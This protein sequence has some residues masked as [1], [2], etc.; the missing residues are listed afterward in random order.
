[1]KPVYITT[2]WDDGNASDMRVADLLLRY[3]LCGTFYVP[4]HFYKGVI[5]PSRYVDLGSNI[6]LGA[7]TIN[8]VTLT[9]VTDEQAQTEITDSK[10]WIEDHTG[11]DCVMFCP[12]NGKYSPAT[13]AP[14]MREA[15]F[16]ACRTVEGW[17]LDEPRQH[18]PLLNLPTSVQ[19]YPTTLSS[20]V[21]NLLKRRSWDGFK[22]YINHGIGHDWVTSLQRVARQ[23][24][25]HGGVIHLWGH[26]WEIDETHQWQ[27][28]ESA[29]RFLKQLCDST[30]AMAMTNGQ[31]AQAFV[32][33][34]ATPSS[35]AATSRVPHTAAKKHRIPKREW[36]TS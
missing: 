14:M 36:Q 18:G 8:H 32:P 1:M 28:L 29:C 15:N 3:G 25:R 13:H 34:H 4:R 10:S 17:S 21:R 12:P 19:A 11:Q 2:S 35:P 33:S 9:Q 30:P 6:E 24:L 22:R 7:H 5:S 16:L 27:A 26:S 20:N 31:L 23:A